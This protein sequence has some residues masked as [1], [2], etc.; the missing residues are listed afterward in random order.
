[1]SYPYLNPTDLGCQSKFGRALKKY[2]SLSDYT[3]AYRRQ[4][5]HKNDSTEISGLFQKSLWNHLTL[6][7]FSLT[8]F[9]RRS[10]FAFY[11]PFPNSY[12]P[13]RISGRF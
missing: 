6:F 5:F 11:F 4:G 9:L 13:F 3:P 2:F 12:F 10:V 7:T 8:P 1:M